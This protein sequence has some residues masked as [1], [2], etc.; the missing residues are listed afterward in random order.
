MLEG[1][2]GN[3]FFFLGV[4][5]V[6]GLLLSIVKGIWIP[7]HLCVLLFMLGKHLSDRYQGLQGSLKSGR[8]YNDRIVQ[9]ETVLVMQYMEM[10]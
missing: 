4:V 6:I 2:N 10:R 3:M 5:Q 8:N 9:S 1:Q 7:D